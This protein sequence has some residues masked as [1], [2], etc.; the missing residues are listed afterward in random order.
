MYHTLDRIDSSQGYSREN[1][2]WATAREQAHNRRNNRDTPCVYERH[3]KFRAQLLV[4]GRR[5]VTPTFPTSEEAEA[6]LDLLKQLY[7]EYL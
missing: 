7:A 5:L 3:G 6:S 4:C 1:C 2:R